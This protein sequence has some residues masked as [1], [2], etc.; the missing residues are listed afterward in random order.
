VANNPEKRATVHFAESDFFIGVTPSGHAVTLDA[1]DERL[2]APTPVELLMVALGSCTGVDVISILKK[3]R[4]HVTD[5]RIE[6]TGERRDENP[7]SFKLLKVHHLV[8]GHSISTQAVAQAIELSDKKYC[9]VAAT[10]R[11]TAEILSTFEII[12]ESNVE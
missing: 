8:K 7:R 11:P 2:A 12:E 10:L 9:S 5:Y 6:V 4:Q 1:N 3:K